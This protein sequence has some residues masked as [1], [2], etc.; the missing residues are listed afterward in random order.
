MKNLL[1]LLICILFFICTG[2]ATA[3][4]IAAPNTPSVAANP[5]TAPQKEESFYNIR[6]PW[7]SAFNPHEVFSSWISLTMNMDLNKGI[8]IVMMGNPKVNW[9]EAI[10]KYP[11]PNDIPFPP[12]EITMV[13]TFVF[14]LPVEA[15]D[16]VEL[17]GYGYYDKD[18]KM[19]AFRWDGQKYRLLIEGKAV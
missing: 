18:W 17:V 6:S 14:G 15:E 16:K 5:E 12:G 7:D 4:I 3:E 8:M 13:V 1:V 2:C 19:M 9:E 11:N 10:V